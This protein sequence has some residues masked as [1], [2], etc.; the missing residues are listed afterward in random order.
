MDLRPVAVRLGCGVVLGGLLLMALHTIGWSLALRAASRVGPSALG[1]TLS[2]TVVSMLISGLVWTRVLAC[3]GHRTGV[4]LGITLY[5]ATGLAA[6]LGSGAGAA[7]EC[8]LLLRR[9]GVCAGRAVL[10]LALASLI[11]FLGCVVWAPCGLALLVAPAARGALPALGPH[12]PLAVIIATALCG[13]GALAVLALVTRCPG[14]CSRWPVIRLLVGPSSPPV[15][16]SLR[17]LLG[18]IPI[19]AIGWVVGAVPLWV[20]V[21]AIAPG[22]AVSLPAAIGMQSVAAVIGSVAF[23][24]PNGLGARDGAILGLLVAVAGVPIPAAAAAVVLAR[25]SDPVSKA[26]ILVVLAG[27]RRVPP[28]SLSAPRSRRAASSPAYASLLKPVLVPEAGVGSAI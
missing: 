23:F 27:L 16:L 2:L 15:R 20:L 8:I 24:L 1:L 18:L 11:G 5:A 12:G 25:L 28:L 10:L 7:G 21:R 26:L 19:A 9:H 17:Y 13:V 22:S 6:Y 14:E 4:Q 3:L